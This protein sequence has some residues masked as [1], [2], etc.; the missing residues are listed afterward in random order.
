M[1]FTSSIVAKDFSDELSQQFSG[2]FDG[3]LGASGNSI[4]YQKL[5]TLSNVTWRLFEKYRVFVIFDEIHHCAGS[6][7]LDAN[8]WGQPIINKI[9][10]KAKYSIALTGTPWRSDALP[11]ALSQYCDNTKKIQCDYI[12]GLKEAILDKVCR[13]P[14]IIALDN[15][16]I[17]VIKGEETSHFTSFK[18]LLS[19]SVIPYSDIVTNDIVIEQ[20]LNSAKTAL[21]K[22]R[23]KNK[24]AGGLIIA[25]SIDHAWQIELI[26]RL[27]IGDTAV[28]VTSNEADG[29]NIIRKF[30]FGSNKWIIG[31]G[32]I[33]EGTNIPRLQVCCQLTNI[34]TEL[35]FIQILGRILRMTE[36]ANQDAFIFIP[37]EPKLVKYPYS[38]AQKILDEVDTVQIKTMGDALET[39]IVDFEMNESEVASEEHK[40]I[41]F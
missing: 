38:V 11:I 2:Y 12:Y 15:D 16:N 8:A 35:H 26:L 13:T 18:D 39:E 41:F 19:Q 23:L 29:N 30:R 31:V 1:L 34:K 27:T 20:L 25:S 24:S 21:D 28:V 37:A 3:S 4:T 22:I 6:S 14:Q 9:K 10:D 32:M 5:N 33:S 7:M 40:K 36:S 17:T